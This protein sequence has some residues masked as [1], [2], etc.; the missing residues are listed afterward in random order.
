MSAFD[1]AP[2]QDIYSFAGES[3]E[4]SRPAA[5]AGKQCHSEREGH[6]LTP[7]ELAWRPDPHAQ[8]ESARH[9]RTANQQSRKEHL[10]LSADGTYSVTD[11]DSLSTIAER[12][13]RGQRTKLTGKSIHEE[14]ARIV[15]LNRDAYPDLSR[16]LH[17]VKRGM[18][19]RMKADG[20]S[21]HASDGKA[22][23]ETK[24]SNP[25]SG[26]SDQG[27]PR[28]PRDQVVMLRADRHAEVVRYPAPSGE[29]MLRTVLPVMAGMFG[30]GMFGNRMVGFGNH[31]THGAPGLH[32]M[33]GGGDML[34][35][36]GGMGADP[37]FYGG[38]SEGGFYPGRDPR[39][40]NPRR[41]GHYVG[42]GYMDSDPRYN[43]FVGR[44]RAPWYY[45]GSDYDGFSR[46][47]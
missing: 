39:F 43:G 30:S 35:N 15:D 20:C 4:A 18:E 3:T 26:T 32:G 23:R 31:F 12:S 16:N 34:W 27:Q 36:R 44:S 41:A 6:H 9:W 8:S 28:Q 21:D 5:K 37:R 24:A 46:W 25:E 22:H 11:A 17:L 29:Q 7:R 14:I 1:L 33:P 13:L 45:N 10:N 47:G 38:Y 2:R 19:L 40:Y 42:G